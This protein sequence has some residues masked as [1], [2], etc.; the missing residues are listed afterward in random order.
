M[1]LTDI[2]RE[3]PSIF[4]ITHVCHTARV[5]SDTDTMCGEDGGSAQDLVGKGKVQCVRSL[6]PSFETGCF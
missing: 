2:E 4:A 1:F 3:M 5:C 6:S